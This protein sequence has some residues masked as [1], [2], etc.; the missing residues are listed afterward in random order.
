[1]AKCWRS[2]SVPV[3]AFFLCNDGRKE[4]FGL[5]FWCLLPRWSPGSASWIVI[6]GVHATAVQ[7]IFQFCSVICCCKSFSL[8]LFH[9]GISVHMKM[10]MNGAFLCSF[11]SVEFLFSLV[12]VHGSFLLWIASLILLEVPEVP[13]V[14]CEVKR[15]LPTTR[16]LNHLPYL[17]SSTI[18]P[19]T[20]DTTYVHVPCR[21]AI[22]VLWHKTY[23][24]FWKHIW[25]TSIML[26]FCSNFNPLLILSSVS[27]WGINPNHASTCK[28]NITLLQSFSSI[29]KH[30]YL[31]LW[32]LEW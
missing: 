30:L 19:L 5:W 15:Q 6:H 20:T 27:D 23:H 11:T 29:N 13:R 32:L 1:M 7:Q 16:G 22:L 9:F 10:S 31:S 4:G 24:I 17:S 28:R 8:H 2:F 3:C 25:E 12:D 18:I 21:E 14:P 26:W